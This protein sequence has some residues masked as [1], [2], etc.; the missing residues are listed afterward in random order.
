MSPEC[1]CPIENGF[2][3]EC[4]SNGP[5]AIGLPRWFIAESYSAVDFLYFQTPGNIQGLIDKFMAEG[6]R[7]GF[8]HLSICVGDF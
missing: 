2:H 7:R 8:V 3:V 5:G 6:R 1:L 4:G